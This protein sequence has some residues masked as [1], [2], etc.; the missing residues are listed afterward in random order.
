VE[1]K[2]DV[3]T[4]ATMRRLRRVLNDLRLDQLFASDQIIFDGELFVMPKLSSVAVS[5]IATRL[6]QLSEQASVMR[7][8]PSEQVAQI[9]ESDHQDA[10]NKELTEFHSTPTGYAVALVKVDQ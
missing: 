7:V 9:F 3:S 4:G 2:S 10:L 1:E 6:E 5:R 8:E